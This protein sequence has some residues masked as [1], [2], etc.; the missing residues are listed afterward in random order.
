MSR[1]HPAGSASGSVKVLLPAVVEPLPP[2]S[3][4]IRSEYD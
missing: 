3:S 4:K 1:L 2:T